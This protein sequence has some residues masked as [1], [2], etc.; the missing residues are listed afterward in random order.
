M[1]KLVNEL[2]DDILV[3]TTERQWQNYHCNVSLRVNGYSEKKYR[4]SFVFNRLW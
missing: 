1:V 4:L 2:P 3:V